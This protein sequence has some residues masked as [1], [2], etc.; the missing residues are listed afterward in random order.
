MSHDSKPT[1]DTSVTF[2]NVIEVPAEQVEMF[3][4]QWRERA[5][6]MS[7][8]PGFRDSRLHRAVTSQARFQLVNVAHWDSH[9]AWEAAMANPEFQARMRALE[10]DPNVKVSANPALYRVAATYE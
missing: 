9:E 8:A 5:R 1:D 6:I 10:D 7:T 3:I 4:A 2:I